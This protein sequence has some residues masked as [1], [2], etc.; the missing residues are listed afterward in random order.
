MRW[1]DGWMLG[2]CC[3]FGVSDL[4]L[5]CFWPFP[6]SSSTS[7]KSARAI[8]LGTI[9]GKRRYQ[10]TFIFFLKKRTCEKWIRQKAGPKQNANFDRFWEQTFSKHPI[11]T[12]TYMYIYLYI[13]IFTNCPICFKTNSIFCFLRS[14][15]FFICVSLVL[16]QKHHGFS[17]EVPTVNTFPCRPKV[18]IIDQRFLP[19]DFVVE[20]VRTVEEMCVAIKDK[21]RGRGMMVSYRGW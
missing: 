4:F 9:L 8:K 5:T 7:K 12:Y 14:P 1:M 3:L 17:W 11:C 13:V 20:D 18:Q 15:S 19:H 10:A 21:S 16:H 6:E 2:K